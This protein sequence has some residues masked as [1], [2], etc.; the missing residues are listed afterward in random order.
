[1]SY[2]PDFAELSCADAPRR[3]DDVGARWVED[4]FEQPGQPLQGI[5]LFDRVGISIIG[6]FDASGLFAEAT[7]RLRHSTVELW[8]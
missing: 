6:A 1:M 2:G 4:S 5:G 8:D 3:F 7:T